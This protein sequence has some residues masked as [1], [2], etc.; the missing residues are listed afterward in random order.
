MKSLILLLAVG[1]TGPAFAQQKTVTYEVPEHEFTYRFEGTR[2]D[3]GLNKDAKA[4]KP[5]TSLKLKDFH[6]G[7]RGKVDQSFD[8]RVLIN[9]IGADGPRFD[10][11]WV[12]WSNTSRNWSIVTG[13]QK[14]N[15]WGYENKMHNAMTVFT[16]V[17]FDNKQFEYSP[18]VAFVYKSADAGTISFQAIEDVSPAGGWNAANGSQQQLAYGVE[19]H[20]EGFDVGDAKLVPLFQIGTYDMGHSRV[21]DLGIDY[22]SKMAR[23]VFDY[24]HDLW[25]VKGTEVDSA[26]KSK[27]KKQENTKTNAVVNVELDLD[28]IAPFAHYSIFNVRDY[29]AAGADEPKANASTAAFSDNGRV[30]GVGTYFNGVSKKLRPYAAFERRTGNFSNATGKE[31]EMDV[32]FYKIGL[33]GNF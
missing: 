4:D 1:V 8:Y 28:S 3:D 22:Q 32:N 33:A 21:I 18:A 13:H 23:V 25:V 11:G 30:L 6:L 17:G 14:V 20:A 2:S 29:T 12:R 24:V 27:V 16:S 15:L 10:E 19:W 5:S 7:M 9:L 31:E 26:G